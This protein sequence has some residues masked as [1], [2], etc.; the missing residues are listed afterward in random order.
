MTTQPKQC[1]NCQKNFEIFSEDKT[2]YEKMGVPA[3][4]FCPAC[5]L[6]RRLAWRNERS[7]YRVNCKLCGKDTISVHYKDSPIISYC[8]PCWWS[9]KWDPLSY[10]KEYDFSR[11]FFEQFRELME[12]VPHPNTWVSYKSLV[13]SDYNNMAHGLKNCYWL[14]NSDYNEDCMYGEE[15]ESSKDCIDV[16]MI[17]HS[18]LLYEG[19]NCNKC[20]RVYFSV[21]CEG[22]H[23]VWFSKNLSNCS[24]CFGCI[25][26][27]NQQYHIFNKAYS[28]EEYEQKLKEFNLNSYK[29]IEELK[30]K[31]QE[32]QL[33]FPYKYIHGRNNSNVT[34]DYIY[35]SKDVKSSYIVTESEN[36]KYS[37][38]L[39]VKPNKDC[40]DYTQFG[41]N[42][43]Q[44]YEA[45]SCGKGIQ[46]IICSGPQVIEGRAIR[47]S[48]HC[49]NNSSNLFGCIGLR[50][51]KYCILNKQYTQDEYEALL[52]KIIQHMKDAPYKD[53][54]GRV[55]G[56]GE[57]SP[58]GLSHFAYNETS[59]Y[60]YYPL[61][62]EKALEKG[63]TWKDP[64]EKNLHITTEGKDLPDS[65]AE[66]GDDI[67]NQ[68]ISCVHWAPPAGGCAQQCTRAFRILPAEF[69]F[70]KEAGIPLPRLCPNCR[71]FERMKQRNPLQ[72]WE[73]TCLCA[74]QAS[75]NGIYKNTTE[76]FHKAEHCPN[77]FETTYSPER[78]EI[79]Y[80]EECYLKEV[81]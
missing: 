52:P 19:V 30:K 72:L 37:M 3:P 47:Y 48:I 62:K 11:P 38:W 69:K 78:K 22:C 1:Q 49:S 24:D 14:F 41:E 77:T 35:H 26:L 9:D 73:R 58:A 54:K 31:F 53:K 12:A 64:E 17:D 4:T 79:V 81:T 65:I 5:R 25:N 20:S 46:E 40:Y 8:G 10:G 70:Y 50:A 60:E 29:S 63:Y 18:E 42:A 80:C 36:C 45:I 33:Q 56:Y 21:D 68:V 23:N 66:V 74:G 43:Q 76:H 15:V 6:Q 28:K 71:H 7:L 13:N 27:K 59:A 34:G 39:I 61:T 75:E 44:V 32:F 67:T 57:F 55:Y 51:K 2:F 16:T